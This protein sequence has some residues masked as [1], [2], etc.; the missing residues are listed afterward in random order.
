[1]KTR[2]LT[3]LAV[4]LLL[5]GCAA[6]T[7]PERTALDGIAIEKVHSQFTKV[8]MVTLWS[9]DGG[10]AVR[11]EVARKLAGR[12]PIYGHVHV[13]LLDGE[14]RLLRRIDVDHRRPGVGAR[15]AR[16][17]VRQDTDPGTVAVVRVIHH[18]DH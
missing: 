2:R 13:D 8:G 11:G 12:G 10:F 17:V 9:D 3:L 14:Q 5:T 18:S 1:M 4:S 16:F 15:S 6:L 7:G